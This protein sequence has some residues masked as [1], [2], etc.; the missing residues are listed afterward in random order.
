MASKKNKRR[1]R[2][3][4]ENSQEYEWRRIAYY[5]EFFDPEGAQEF[6]WDM[7]KL[8]LTSFDDDGEPRTRSNFIFY[9]EH[10]KELIENISIILNAR[11]K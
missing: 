6:L 8:A 9:Y 4:L 10:T 5:F 1:K 2:K 11:S 7:F 3:E